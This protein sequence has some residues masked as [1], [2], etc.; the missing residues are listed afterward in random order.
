MPVVMRPPIPAV[1][2]SRRGKII[3]SVV[4]L[5][6]LLLTLANSFVGVYIDWL[7]FGE[8][9]YRSVYKKIFFT[10]AT[11]VVVFGLLM[12]AAIA[13][14]LIITYVLRPPFRPMSAEQ[15]NLERYR[16]ILESRKKL[17]FTV[18]VVLAGLAAGLSAQSNWQAWLLWRNGGSFGIKDPQFGKDISFFAFDYPIFR[19][20]LGFGF[21][22][23]IFSLLLAIALHYLFGS[24]RLQ[25][26]GQ[27]ISIAARR[28][29][30][31]LVFIFILL[32][33]VGYWLDRYGLVYSDRGKVTGASYTDVNASLPAKTILFWIAIILAGLVF[34]S[35]WLKSARLPAISF[36]VLLI[37][38]IVING[39]YPA[40]VQQFTVKPNASDKEAVYIERNIQATRQAYGVVTNTASDP[41]GTVTYSSFDPSS[42]PS[43]DSIVATDPT[44]SNIRIL[45]P[46]IVSSTFAATQQLQNYYGFPGKLDIDRYTLTDPTSGKV[47]TRDY[48]VGVRELD[49]E[50]LTGNQAN[51]INKRT[52]YTHGYGFVAAAADQ[53]ITNFPT[54]YTEKDIPSTGPLNLKVP[55][56]YYGELGTDYV[57][58]GAKGDHESDGKGSTSTYTG[59]GGIPLDNFLTRLAFASKYKET[60]FLLNDAVT[61]PNAKVMIVR[62]PRARVQKAAPFLKVDGDPYPVVDSV[63][64]HIVWMVDA[65]TTM[66]AYPYSEKESL[67]SLTSDSLTTADKTAAQPDDQ[68]NYIRNSVKATVD[69]FDGTVKLYQW[70]NTDPLIKAWSKSFP[71]LIQPKT[72]MPPQLVAHVRYPQDLFEAQRAVLQQYHV[73]DP[74][75]FYNQLDKWTVPAD[76][77]S[78]DNTANQPPY[79]V[80]AAS[81]TDRQD[82]A[83]A[84][85]FQLT[86]PMKVN[87]RPYLAAYIS[88]NSDPGKNYGKISVLRLPSGSSV[89]G[90]EQVYATFNA[91]AVISKDI[92]LLSGNGSTP[93]HG[94][95]LTLPVGDSFLYVEPLYV[96]G[97][98]ANAFPI[99]QRVLV[100][101]GGKIGYGTTLAMALM[102]LN[103]PVV[104]QGIGAAGTTTSPPTTSPPSTS[105]APTT[106]PPAG[107]AS[108]DSILTQ[109]DT[110]FADLQ[111]AYKSG[112]LSQIGLYQQQI[113]QLTQEYLAAR[114][115]PAPASSKAPS[116][117]SPT[118]SAPTSASKTP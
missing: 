37:L 11:L 48:V 40:L 56:V 61:S 50:N 86:T 115:T 96:K 6:F 112:N 4:V 78:P 31:V 28:H 41:N 26:P 22:M 88:V 13:A 94:N 98:S 12:A 16:V 58:V 109:L 108:I 73:D 18:V 33:A 111:G 100:E 105:A 14:N 36:V 97:V 21:S 19:I 2:L 66:A 27:K 7:W 53:D 3:I 72:A 95:L 54:T 35:I 113:A 76:P 118:S 25:T 91:N 24:I 1:S 116:G 65:Y 10:R 15:Q 8:V 17:A 87:G 23:V 57:V 39:I 80:L 59:T 43:T 92:S 67:A 46:N 29:I 117:S 45:D 106:V 60:N 90:P 74:V 81:P 89:N 47:S 79:Y 20:L 68:V 107:S 101:Y 102:N 84:P 71:G 55:Q 9:G 93:L 99:L 75:E 34:A 5:V 51:W 77:A 38:S 70:D 82:T 110:A 85:E 114:G 49:T 44:V 104:G 83:A 42:D 32:K 64:G 103:E 30:T 62:D 63:T 69:A 52:V